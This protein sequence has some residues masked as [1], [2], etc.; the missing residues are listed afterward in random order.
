MST[1]QTKGKVVVLPFA[2]PRHA[3]LTLLTEFP[4][5]PHKAAG[6]LG[7]MCVAEVLTDKQRRWLV[8]LLEKRG[9]PPLSEG[10]KE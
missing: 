5:L 7:H 10:R 9:L 3:A 6:F 2:N 8:S 1:P 4:D